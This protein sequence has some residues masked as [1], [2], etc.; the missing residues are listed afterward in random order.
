M[1]LENS[2]NISIS[3]TKNSDDI[4]RFVESEVNR[5]ISRKLLLDGNI[6][7][8][9]KAKI[10]K[11]LIDGAQGMFRWV[12]MS[13]ESLQQIKFHKDFK[14]ALGQLPSKLSGLYDIIHTQIDQTGFYGRRVATMTLKWLL[15]AQRLLS[16]DELIAAIPGVSEDP[17]ELSSD[18]DEKNESGVERKP[19]PENDII[20]LCRNLVVIDSEQKIFRFAHQSVR[21]YLLSRPEY[22]I[23]EQH[24]L[25]AERC[26]D[27]YLTGSS[28]G[29]LTSKA[30]EQN[31]LKS[32]AMV[33][34][35]VHYK[36]V[37]EHQSSA[38]REKAIRFTKQGSNTSPSYEQWTSDMHS[39]CG[40]NPGR[41]INQM[42]GLDLED[43]LGHRLSS[44]SSR[45]RTYLN[46]A[47]AFGFLSFMKDYELSSTDWNQHQVLDERKNELLCIATKEGH[48]QTIQFL[49]DKGADINA[50]D[51]E[52]GSPLSAAS[53][54]GY[55]QIV[56]MLLDKGADINAQGGDCGNALQAASAGGYDQI[57][58]ILLDKGA[59]I[60]AQGGDCG[61]AL[62]AASAGGNNQ[63]VQILLDKGADINAQG[64]QYGNA[65]QAASAEGY[66]Q[67]VQILLDKGADI[68]A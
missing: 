31:A 5:L 13:L 16:V 33:Y 12:A 25:A 27:V 18:S 58:Q 8:K 7:P 67:I 15:C 11:T 57:V 50:Q 1:H 6:R 47:C 59:D 68:N 10:V 46:A 23:V 51:T 19:S 45:P 49:L 35:P 40:D 53:A 60:N 61:N 2:K 22:T 36:Y 4:A 52:F 44:A 65:L 26:F 63:I 39:Q 14:K 48:H 29:I 24:A 43:R 42:F 38:L 55:D 9:F 64:G 3:A 30:A 41:L 20:R 21:E 56:Q 32:Y 34:W 28:P 66:D 54:R 62:Q 37:E 17:T